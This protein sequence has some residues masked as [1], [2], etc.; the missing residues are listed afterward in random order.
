VSTDADDRLMT[1]T[2][3]ERLDD[4]DDADGSGIYIATDDD[5]LVRAGRILEIEGNKVY[6]QAGKSLLR[7][8]V[9]VTLEPGAVQDPEGNGNP[10]GTIAHGRADR[11]PA[12]SALYDRPSGV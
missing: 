3:D 10:I 9:G 8:L 11:L 4:D 12:T 7:S 1:L 6:V 2:F 5:R